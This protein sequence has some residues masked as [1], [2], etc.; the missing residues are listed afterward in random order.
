VPRVA[1]IHPTAQPPQEELVLPGTLQAYVEAPIYAR[2]S[3]YIRSWSHDI[4]SRVRKGETLVEL[5][6]PEVDQQLSQAH[7]EL[8]TAKANARLAE[9]TATR[10]EGLLKTNAVSRQEVDNAAGEL[11]AKRAVVDAAAANVGRLEQLE[12]FKHVRAPFAGAITRRNADVGTLVNAG[13]GGQAQLLFLLAQTSPLRV[14]VGVPE[15]YAPSIRPGTTAHLALAEYPGREFRGEVVRSSEAIDPATR[16]RLTEVNVSNQD[17]QLLPGGYAQVHLQL[18]VAAA[19][20]K[21]PVN[22]LLFRSEGLRVCVV[23]SS[24]RVRLRALTVGRD[25]GVALEVLDGLEPEEWIVLN[26]PDALEEGQ[27][28]RPTPVAATGTPEATGA[29]AK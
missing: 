3:G 8:A 11:E 19:R 17:G 18:K 9:I 22:A 25:Y 13:N 4:G 6:T 15:R 27:L 20:L 5:D 12:S 21:V 24:Q 28:V 23:D 7:G 16:T 2:T 29:A 1:V 14:Y 10:L 26:P